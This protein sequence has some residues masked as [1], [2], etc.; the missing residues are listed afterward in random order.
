MVRSLQ[1]YS[2]HYSF[3][4]IL[5]S[6]FMV[7]KNTKEDILFPIGIVAKMFGI[8]VATLRLYES[9]GLIIPLKSKGRHRFY[10]NDDIKRI[11]CIRNLIEEKGLNL[12]GIR[13]LLSTIPCWELKPCSEDD[14]KKCDAYFTSEIPCWM[15]ENKGE[16]C[17]NENCRDCPVY[18]HSA[19]CNNIKFIL[20]KYWRSKPYD[21]TI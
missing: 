5:Q 12:T 8:S 6:S 18:T 11:E 10:N 7:E 21:E 15:V 19:Q 16:R 2:L 13:M 9:E 3:N 1:I 20:K 14:R 17:K 4:Y